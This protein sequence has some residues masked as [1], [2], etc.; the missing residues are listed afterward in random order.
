MVKEEINKLKKD[1]NY[2]GLTEEQFDK[3][4]NLKIKLKMIKNLIF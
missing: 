1:Y 3:I 4:I 2:L